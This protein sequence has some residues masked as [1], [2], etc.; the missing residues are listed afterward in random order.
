MK[1]G[2]EET[3]KILEIKG[4]TFN[5]NYH[6]DNS[7]DHMPDWQFADGVFL[8]VTHTKHNN[9]IVVEPNDFHKKSIKEK[10][11][12]IM[13][14]N[15][16]QKI[17]K[18][19][20]AARNNPENY[21]LAQKRVKKFFG[22]DKTEFNCDFPIIEHSTDKIL[23]RIDDKASK[24]P[25]NTYLFIFITQDESNCLKELLSSGIVNGCYDRFMNSILES[26]FKVVFL[27]EWDFDKQSYDQDSPFL[28]RFD[29][30]D[31]KKLI[32]KML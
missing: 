26:P 31:N 23:H 2:E 28:I 8:E 16:D 27:C 10:L 7:G 15:S 5:E 4:Y 29:C 18:D 3:K 12:K 14:I 30:V 11:K 22:T 24:H 13:Q 1:N 20:A 32:Y 9:H 17:L 21:K 6:D 19:P 25:S